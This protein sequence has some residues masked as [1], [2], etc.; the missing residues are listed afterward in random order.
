MGKDFLSTIVEHKKTEV[1]SARAAI[2]ETD[3]RKQA[4]AQVDVREKRPFFDALKPGPGKSTVNIIAEIKRASPSKG[5]ICPDLDPAS[6]AGEYEKGGAAAISV[7]TDAKYF[8][9]ST[10]DFRAARKGAG[11]G[12]LRKDFLI[13][14]YQVYESFLLGADAVLLIARILEKEEMKDYLALSSELGMDALVEIHSES[15][16]EAANFAGATLV[17]INNRNLSSFETDLSNAVDLSAL[18]SPEQVAVAASGIAGPADIE[19]NLKAGIHNFL[20]GESLV[21]ASDTVAFLKSLSKIG[22]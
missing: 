7:L 5:D 13:S 21:R 3:I 20:I 4:E 14:S 18:L 15:D 22:S 2:S 10:D 8:K 17:G 12:M 9:G 16:L 11:L 1:E 19:R 6:L